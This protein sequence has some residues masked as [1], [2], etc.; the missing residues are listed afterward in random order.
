MFIKCATVYAISVAATVTVT[1]TAAESKAEEAW[2]TEEHKGEA[3]EPT[4]NQAI[5]ISCTFCLTQYVEI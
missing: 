5:Y 4:T 2:E 1:A 3:R